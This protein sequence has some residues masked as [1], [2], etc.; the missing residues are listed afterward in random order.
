V[1]FNRTLGCPVMPLELD[2]EVFDNISY[3][4]VDD[5]RIT[6]PI[7]A[8]IEAFVLAFEKTLH[9][10]SKASPK[11]T[12]TGGAA[13]A[14]T[15]SAKSKSSPAGGSTQ[16]QKA[17][18][19]GSDAKHSDGAGGAASTTTCRGKLI[20]S[21]FDKVTTKHWFSSKEEKKVWERW[22]IPISVS[23]QHASN[24]KVQSASSDQL[25]ALRQ[26]AV[27]KR[28]LYILQQVNEHKKHI[29]STTNKK[30][31]SKLFCYP[32]DISFVVGNQ[33]NR[34]KSWSFGSAIKKLIK[35]GPPRLMKQT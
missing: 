22:V 21:F 2:C 31:N 13:T 12:G 28:L 35:Q 7:E 16:Q 30:N 24:S 27:K 23:Q 25:D 33:R 4:C 34:E 18:P 14:P 32:F 5:E 11:R 15:A 3:A 19:S 29:P 8:K 26:Q 1:L 6:K 10:T 20:L 17:S 9:A